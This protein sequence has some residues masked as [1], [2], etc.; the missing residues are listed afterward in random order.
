MK[1]AEKV[2]LDLA[3]IAME[4]VHEV[5][6][7]CSLVDQADEIEETYGQVNDVIQQLDN[8]HTAIISKHEA[9]FVVSYKQHMVRIEQELAE[10]KLK[11]SEHYL[12]LRKDRKIQL[13]ESSIAIFRAEINKMARTIDEL[14]TQMKKLSSQLRFVAGERDAWQEEAKK[15]KYQNIIL[16]NTV[17]ELKNPLLVQKYENLGRETAKHEFKNLIKRHQ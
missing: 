7:K 12:R 16:R 4:Q 17:Q 14:R 2:Q 15:S 9:D 13:L 11:S 10:F 3:K 1:S 5:L 6:S 8:L